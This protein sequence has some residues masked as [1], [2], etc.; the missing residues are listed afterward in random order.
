MPTNCG[1]QN[2]E[3]SLTKIILTLFVLSVDYLF[4]LSAHRWFLKNCIDVFLT[5]K[6]LLGSTHYI[7]T[8]S[9]PLE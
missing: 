7:T 9:D 4:L 6:W 2:E 1:M 3:N 5:E 8:D